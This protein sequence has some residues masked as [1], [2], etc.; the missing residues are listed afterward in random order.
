[1]RSTHMR[2][3][4]FIAESSEQIIAEWEVFA[5]SCLPAA[6]AMDLEQRRDHVAGMLKAISKDLET[7]QTKVE[8]SEKAIGNDDAHVDSQTASNAHGTDRAASGYTAGQMVSEFR[9]LRA[10]VLRLWADAQSDFNRANLEEVT[11][12]NEAI[13]QL[14]AESITKYAQDVDRLKDLF[15]GVLGHDL[16]NPL[17]AIMMSATLLMASEG[18]EWRNATTAARILRSGTRM[19]A[20]IGDLLDFTRARLGAG[21]PITRTGVDLE[22]ECR[23]TADEIAAFHPTCKVTFQATGELHGLWDGARI[24]QAL[25]NLLGN[26]VQ[27]GTQDCPITVTLRG[28]ADRV[29]LSVHNEGRP[30]PERDLQGIFDPF[31]QLAPGHATSNVGLGLYI[32]QSIVAAHSGTVH[33]ESADDGTTFT[34]RLPRVA[35][36][37]HSPIGR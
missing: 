11:R 17:G 36:P 2:L 16:R 33:V 21:I 9:A 23:K 14:L 28:E 10:S 7:P 35:T 20:L 26:A 4:Q 24:A 13:D 15:L 12:F 22:S 8:Q 5:R 27:H 19:E 29:V 31:R 30:I 1:M 25:S 3:S 37:D 6:N 32:V 34:I 18:P